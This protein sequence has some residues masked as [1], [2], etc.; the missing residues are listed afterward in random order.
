MGG[1]AATLQSV[2]TAAVDSTIA[3][4]RWSADA[5]GPRLIGF[6]SRHASVGSTAIVQDGD[7]LLDIVAYG[8]DAASAYFA[9][10][11]GMIRFEVDGT[12]GTNDMPGRITLHTSDDGG[13][14]PAER[15]RI[16]NNGQV[17]IGVTPGGSY[18]FQV[19]TLADLPRAVA[20]FNST[21]SDYNAT[22]TRAAHASFDYQVLR[23]EAVRAAT[24]SYSFLTTTSAH[25]GANDL[26]HVLYGDGT[27]NANGAWSSSGVDYAEYFEWADG[28]PGN[29]DRVG[30]SVSLVGEKIKVAESGETVIGI[31]SGRPSFVA[32]NAELRWNQ[33]YQKDEF[34]RYVMEDYEAVTWE[35]DDFFEADDI[36]E[37]VLVGKKNVK[38]ARGIQHSYADDEIPD[39]LSVPDDATRTTQQRK[40]LNPSFDPDLTYAPRSGRKEWSAIGMVGKLGMYKNQQTNSNWIKLRDVSD[41]VE[42]WLVR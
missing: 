7:S 22:S 9:A 15:M 37:G 28:N 38:K 30:K 1:S 40:K 26:E 29:E 31:V 35:V 5:D 18:A 12:P 3:A 13:E 11:A 14:S 34:D 41:E 36:Q 39:G 27:S 32:G 4:A 17:G 16:D 19:Q 2:G 20:Q 42:E 23:I 6:K 21:L 33:K 8:D 10:P 24:T 25:G